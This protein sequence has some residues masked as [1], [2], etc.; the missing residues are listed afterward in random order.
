MCTHHWM[1]DSSSMGVCKNCG[2][3]KDFRLRIQF[4]PREKVFLKTLSKAVKCD[5]YL[6]GRLVEKN[7]MPDY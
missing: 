1:L 6:Q 2:Q 7:Y 4:T 3:R 5:F